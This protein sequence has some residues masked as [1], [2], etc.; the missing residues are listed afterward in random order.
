MTVI[1]KKIPILLCLCFICGCYEDEAELTLNSSGSGTLKQKL[2]I[3]E[4]LVVAGSDSSGNG[5][6]PP[7]T[8][9]KVL[10]EIGS[11][12]DVTS[13]RQTDMPDGGRVVEFEG[14]F[15]RPERL[16]LS[17]FCR[18]TL[19]LR[20]SPID[21]NKAVIYYDME[22]SSSSRP[23]LAQLYGIAKGLHVRRTIHLPVK[24]DKTNG[25]T[26]MNNHTVSWVMDLRDK[27]GLTRTKA[28]LEGPDK[29]K[30]FAIFDVSAME[31]PLPLKAG[32]DISAEGEP[33]SQDNSAGLA[34]KV[35]WVSLKKKAGIDV[36]DAKEVSDLEIGIELS[37]IEGHEP[38]ACLKPVLLSLMDDQNNDLVSKQT[39]SRL[40]IFGSDK[41]NRKKELILKAETPAQNAKRLKNLSGYVEVIT[42]TVK[43]NVILESIQ[44]LAGKETTGNDILNKLDFRIKSIEGYKLKIEIEGGRHTITSL[45]VF[46]KDGSRISRSGGMGMG[47]EYTYEF[48]EA[49]P[50]S[51]KC[52]LEVIV[53]EDTVKIPFSLEEMPLP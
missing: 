45:D 21:E 52:E 17:E 7:V 35:S 27:D 28:F 5:N 1:R 53:S 34:A 38:V 11:V 50:G 19:K 14:T 12:I 25:Q 2:I 31:F 37:W 36:V 18:N 30:G 51:A 26:S 24:I 47:N 9:E 13:I 15:D 16:F 40:M 44:Q 8:K 3:S 32:K 48:D 41:I 4:R 22:S 43:E 29:G 6:T 49:I 42:K 10:K 39:T 46:K 20:I 23:S 33:K